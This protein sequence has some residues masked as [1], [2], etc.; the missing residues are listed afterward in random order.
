MEVDQSPSQPLYSPVT[1]CQPVKQANHEKKMDQLNEKRM[2]KHPEHP[3]IEFM[4]T[5]R[6]I[7]EDKRAF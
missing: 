6:D 2:L 3:A 4:A 7:S 5:Y 1:K